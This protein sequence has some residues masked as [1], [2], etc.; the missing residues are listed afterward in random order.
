MTAEA[1]VRRA[2]RH[3]ETAERDVMPAEPGDVPGMAAQTSPVGVSL[4]RGDSFLRLLADPDVTD[5]LVNGPGDVWQERNGFLERS[6]VRVD[7]DDI[8]ALIERLLVPSGRRVDRSSPIVDARLADGSRINVVLTPVAVD[9]PCVTI[10]CFSANG[11]SLDEFTN[12]TVAIALAAAVAQ[13]RSI[14]VSGATGA[15]KTTM[16]NA[17]ALHIRTGERIITIED[18]A[19][20]HLPGDHV[21][22]L[23]TRPPSPEGTGRVTVGDLVRNALRMRPDRLI[24]G[25]CRGVETFDMVQAMHTGHRGSLTTVHANDAA[26]AL[27]RLESMMVTAQPEVPVSVL[28]TQL[29]SAIDLVVHLDRDPSG[30]RRVAQIVEVGEVCDGDAIPL[31]DANMLGVDQ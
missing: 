30:N 20:L 5:V 4:Q 22:R 9:G 16:L 28:R 29:A 13:R 8:N 21:V 2:L 26:D 6:G 12:P 23:E 7:R 18:A 27:R 17:L 31:V 24:V 10:R 11:H 3:A 19:E 1:L 15:G 14:V 25:E